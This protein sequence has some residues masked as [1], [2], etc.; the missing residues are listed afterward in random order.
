MVQ[1]PKIKFLMMKKTEKQQI[2][3]LQKLEP[4]N[5]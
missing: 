3:T 1:N 5:I 2:F 4:E